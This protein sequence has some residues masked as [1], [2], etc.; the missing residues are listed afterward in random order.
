MNLNKPVVAIGVAVAI[1]AAA[2]FLRFAEGS[3]LLD[4]DAGTRAFMAATGLIIA[5]MGNVVPKQLKRPRDSLAAERR[6][7]T[8]L[9][10]VGWVMTL[11][12]LIFAGAWI[13][14]PEAVAEPLSMIVLGAA[15]LVTAVTALS[16]RA[17]PAGD[18]PAG[19]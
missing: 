10:R 15:F 5:W 13:V 12:G 16:C 6:V 2:V 11:A 1:L 7:Q 19:R 3:G 18:A 9:R 17:R 14:A 4:G 8:A